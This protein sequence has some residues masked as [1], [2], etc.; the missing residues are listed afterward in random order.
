MQKIRNFIDNTKRLGY[1]GVIRFY[2]F[3]LLFGEQLEFNTTKLLKVIV[4]QR[5]QKILKKVRKLYRQEKKILF[6]KNS[7]TPKVSIL[8]SVY[9]GERFLEEAIDSIL[10]QNFQDFEF[11]IMDDAS[12]DSSFEIL[13][14]YENMDN[15][16]RTFKNKENVGL[17]SSLN[18]LLDKARGCY[19]ARMD[20][21]DISLSERIQQEILFLEA[22]PDVFL[23]G[24]G[25][26]NID[27][28]GIII[29]KFDPLINS[30]DVSKTL[31]I[32]N[33]I[34]HSSIMFRNEG[35]RYRETFYYSQDYDFYLNL[36]TEGKHL[37]NLGDYLLK[38]RV[39]NISVSSNSG[40]SQEYFAKLARASYQSR[41]GSPNEV[42]DFAVNL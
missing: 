7:H 4:K 25:A 42:G 13:Q 1:F 2:L 39:T 10:S 20:S 14:T 8:M 12:E 22:N 11:L 5:F 29:S 3:N 16:I 19:I 24:T 36:L 31:P 15:R 37:T 28:K 27:E 38:Y 35:Y 33:C 6:G 17:T 32:H 18:F 9:N 21:D 34:Y 40:E 23:V 26:I 30:K 41:T